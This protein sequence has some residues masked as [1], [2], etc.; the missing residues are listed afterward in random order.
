MLGIYP[1]TIVVHVFWEFW[2][3]RWAC[4]PSSSLWSTKTW[5]RKGL[6]RM[7]ESVRIPPTPSVISYRKATKDGTAVQCELGAI[8]LLVSPAGLHWS[9]VKIQI[10]LYLPFFLHDSASLPKERHEFSGLLPAYKIFIIF[11]LTKWI[12]TPE[13][14]YNLCCIVNWPTLDSVT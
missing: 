5:G 2:W 6:A 7:R 8:A 10:P 9:W 14:M 1:L 12:L 13:C 4:R 3:K 11:F